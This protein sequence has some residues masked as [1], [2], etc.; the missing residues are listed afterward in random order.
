LKSIGK[1]ESVTN[2]QASKRERESLQMDAE[3]KLTKKK[4]KKMINM[5]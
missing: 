2:H 3:K 1:K 4:S 5:M